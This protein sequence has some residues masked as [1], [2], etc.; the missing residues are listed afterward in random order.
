MHDNNTVNPNENLVFKSLYFHNREELS[1]AF[2]NYQIHCFPV[3][4]FGTV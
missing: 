3:D 2:V 4:N 1:L